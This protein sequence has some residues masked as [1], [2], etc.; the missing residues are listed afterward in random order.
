MHAT[1]RHIRPPFLHFLRAGMDASSVDEDCGPV[2]GSRHLNFVDLHL[3]LKPTFG[4]VCCLLPESLPCDDSG[5]SFGLLL[6]CSEE[7]ALF[8]CCAEACPAALCSSFAMSGII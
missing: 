6:S 7:D 3:V 1:M 5:G 8:S 4:F 2:L